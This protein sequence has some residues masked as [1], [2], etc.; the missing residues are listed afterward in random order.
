MSQSSIIYGV[1]FTFDAVPDEFYQWDFSEQLDKKLTSCISSYMYDEYEIQSGNTCVLGIHAST[2]YTTYDPNVTTFTLNTLNRAKQK[3]ETFVKSQPHYLEKLL[4]S[5]PLEGLTI[6][7]LSEAQCFITHTETSQSE[8]FVVY[9]IQGDVYKNHEDVWQVGLPDGEHDYDLTPLNIAMS[10]LD[11][12]SDEI[13]SEINDLIEHHL[14]SSALLLPFR[15][16]GSDFPVVVGQRVV[17]LLEG[18]SAK[19]FHMVRPELRG[20][21][22]AITQP[23]FHHI[24]EFYGC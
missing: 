24:I 1:E 12:E 21:H 9:G 14:G 13:N 7:D 2:S 4:K 23:E 11:V 10:K 3:W 22:E 6:E 17:S 20:K 8:G 16:Y 19:T 18:A 5:K 15:D